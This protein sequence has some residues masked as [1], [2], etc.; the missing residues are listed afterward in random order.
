MSEPTHTL[1]VRPEPMD[2]PS[3]T[4]L[5]RRMADELN[6]LYREDGITVVDLD[7][8]EFAPPTGLFL[9]ARLGGRP[10]GCGALR[11]LEP[12]VAEVKRMYVEPWA[13]GLGVA[14]TLL[15]ELEKAARS[16]DYRSIRLETGQ[17]QTEAMRLYEAAGYRRIPNFGEYAGRKLSVCFEKLLE[18]A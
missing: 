3:A 18:P 1:T 10:A 14:R 5:T 13:R 7:P 6:A 8:T 11:W 12:N 4:A 2:G 16:L 17:R 9:V 15:G